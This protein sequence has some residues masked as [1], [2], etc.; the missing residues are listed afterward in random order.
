MNETTQEPVAWQPTP[1]QPQKASSKRNLILFGVLG[2]L[3]LAGA[4]WW[5]F[6][7][8]TLAGSIVIPYVSHQKP[9]IDPHLPSSNQLS[10]KLEEIQFDGLFNISASASGIVYEDGLGEF[11]GIDAENIVSVRLK[12]DK[13]W[14]DSYTVVMEK[15][16]L[17]SIDKAKDHSFSAA[18]LQFTLR[19]IQAVGSLSPDYILVSQAIDPMAFEGP[20]A[21]NV[22]RFKFKGDRIWKETDIKEVLS[23]KLLPNGSDMNALNYTN[24]TAEY[25]MLPPKDGVS[26]YHKNPDATATIPVVNLAPY[27]DNS[28]FT[29]ELRNDNINVLLDTPFGSLSQILNDTTDYFTKSNV[30]T[31]FFAV[32][33]NTERLNRDQRKEARKLIDTKA[34]VDRL[35]KV[36]TEQQRHIV[37]YK[38][39]RD[40][41]YDYFNRSVFPSSTYYIEE[42]V[43]EPVVDETPANLSVLP[44][45]IRIAACVN[46]GFREEYNELIEV[47]NAVG[48]GRLKVT[49]VQNDD[50]RRG[51]YDGVLVAN[52][53]YRSNFLFDLYNIFL[54]EPDLQAYTINLETETDATG[55]PTVSTKSFRDGNNFFRL[56]PE[57]NQ[58]E[59]ADILQLLHYVYGFMSTRQ[60][61]DKQEFAR[62]IDVLEHEMALGAWMFSLPSLA[63]FAT[64]FDASSI[65]LYGV[66]SQLSTIE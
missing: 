13:R 33:F 38:G 18:D 22:I 16:K 9:T 51:N 20:D 14:H 40:N 56:D 58:T 35:Y 6:F 55:N 31:A 28:T 53:G 21:Q 44:D 66:A 50:I 34:I 49:A 47:L 41:Y 64:Q 19:R 30:A 3:I 36:G 52:T 15:D 23:F 65:D 61:G 60:I 45:T 24:G 29:T 1:A 63:Y 7:R 43:I 39:N 8:T 5:F 2:L 4:I 48:K 12:T 32:F 17:K 42:K 37:D 54:R 46:F 27:I 25:M 11:L 59:R 57:K 62:R 10:D 26:N